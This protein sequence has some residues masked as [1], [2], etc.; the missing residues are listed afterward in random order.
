[1]KQNH[2]WQAKSSS[3]IKEVRH[4]LWNTKF[5]YR[6]H[7]VCHFSYPEPDE[8]TPHHFH[9]FLQ[10]KFQIVLLSSKWCLSFRFPLYSLPYVL[11]A[12]SIHL[13]DLLTLIIFGKEQTTN[14]GVPHYAII[15][16][17]FLSLPINKADMSSV[18]PNSQT[19]WTHFS[20]N[21]RAQFH[22]Q[23]K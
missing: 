3:A 14:H 13:F 1:M 19:L 20:L 10:D 4:I 8:H 16:P 5:R 9:L 11:C 17:I 12:P 2:S 21:V 6:I 15:F 23:I 7:T 22:T 18:P